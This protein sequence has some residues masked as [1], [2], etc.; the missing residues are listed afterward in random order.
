MLGVW[1][2]GGVEADGWVGWC[3]AGEKRREEGD[4]EEEEEREEGLECCH[5]GLWWLVG[6]V[7][8]SSSGSVAAHLV[9]SNSRSAAHVEDE[10]VAAACGA[11]VS[12]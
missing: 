10:A 3:G 7:V 8:W 9:E 6:V 2:A 5:G 1:G 12:C 11:D 4:D